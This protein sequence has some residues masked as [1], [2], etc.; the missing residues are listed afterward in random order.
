MARA[1]LPAAVPEQLSHSQQSLGS[2]NHGA[3]AP[4]CI[5]GESWGS[6][7]P[8]AAQSPQWPKQLLHAT[9]GSTWGRI[10]MLAIAEIS[11]ELGQ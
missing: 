4:R 10:P 7:G 8:P 1:R 11:S 3:R 6:A 2:A 5:R 9:Q